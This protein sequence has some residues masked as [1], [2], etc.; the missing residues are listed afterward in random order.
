MAGA[1]DDS[2]R[3]S[4][5]RTDAPRTISSR[6]IL[7]DDRIVIIRHEDETYRLQRTAAG[8]LILTK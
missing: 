5:A 2:G 3:S 1:L 6:D 8:K 7:R 4:V